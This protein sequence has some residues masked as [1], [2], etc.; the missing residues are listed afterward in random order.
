M[1]ALQGQTL[2]KKRVEFDISCI[3]KEEQT[4]DTDATLLGE[5]GQFMIIHRLAF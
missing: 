4:V 3:E 2:T 1:L 5:P